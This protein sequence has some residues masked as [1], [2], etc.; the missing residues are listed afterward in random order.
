MELLRAPVGE[1]DANL[2]HDL[3]DRRPHSFPARLLACGLGVPP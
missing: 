2:A 1:V 3:D